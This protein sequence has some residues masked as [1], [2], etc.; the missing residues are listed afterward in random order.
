MTMPKLALGRLTLR[1]NDSEKGSVSERKSSARSSNVSTRAPSAASS[2]QPSARYPGS[3]GN[4]ARA[5]APHSARFANSVASL[6]QAAAAARGMSARC[7]PPSDELLAMPGSLKMTGRSIGGH[8]GQLSATGCSMSSESLASEVSPTCSFLG[9]ASPPQPSRLRRAA[10]NTGRLRKRAC[11]QPSSASALRASKWLPESEVSEAPVE[12]SIP[13]PAF[14]QLRV[15]KLADLRNRSSKTGRL[16]AIGVSLRRFGAGFNDDVQPVCLGGLFSE[17]SFSHYDVDKDGRL[18]AWEL[19]SML[20]DNGM[21]LDYSAASRIL[22]LIA[23]PGVKTIGSEELARLVVSVVDKRRG[24]GGEAGEV[25]QSVFRSY[26]G[27]NSGMLEVPEYTQFLHHLGRRPRT[28]EE[29]EDQGSLVACCRGD[30][31]PGPLNLQEFVILA[32]KVNAGE[33]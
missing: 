19:A 17:E 32:R 29:W 20:R 14:S 18:S 6:C 4:T 7:S 31:Q 3:G 33:E 5:P 22:E 24:S 15:G 21:C 1:R 28:K 2:R 10:Q 25:L 30:G 11:Q 9:W 16:G 13:I 27:N 26:D 8:A 12:A 23:G